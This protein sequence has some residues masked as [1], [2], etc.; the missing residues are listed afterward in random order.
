MRYFSNDKTSNKQ[1]H[2]LSKK[3]KKF[4]IMFQ[5]KLKLPSYPTHMI[6]FTCKVDFKYFLCMF[7]FP[8]T[9]REEKLN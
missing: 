8:N 7:M 3:K 9:P 6:M 4:T 5:D 1:R 2:S